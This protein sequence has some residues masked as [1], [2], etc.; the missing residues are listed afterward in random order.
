M[1]R[2]EFGES[3]D[4]GLDRGIDPAG[5]RQSLPAVHHAMRDRADRSEVRVPHERVQQRARGHRI[6]SRTA[7]LVEVARG[8][9]P[10]VAIEGIQAYRGTA[11]VDGEQRQAG[12]LRLTVWWVLQ[13]S[14]L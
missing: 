10:P 8:E 11:D 2:G 14:N 1:Q 7:L 13:D 3:I 4:L 6:G 9:P 12:A 5:G